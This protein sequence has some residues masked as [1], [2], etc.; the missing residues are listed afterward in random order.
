MVARRVE[1]V[2]ELQDA[3][4]HAVDRVELVDATGRSSRSRQCVIN[5]REDLDAGDG[6]GMRT[7]ESSVALGSH[8]ARHTGAQ[9]HWVALSHVLEHR[10]AI[11]HFGNVL[12]H[13][14]MEIQ[15]DATSVE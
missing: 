12:E 5:V 8:D 15:P 1:L 14:V 4:I 13:Q 7:N 11:G 9:R 2:V 10:L 6:A 3:R